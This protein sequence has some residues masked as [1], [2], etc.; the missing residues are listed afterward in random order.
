MKDSRSSRWQVREPTTAVPANP[1]P[2][3]EFR[4]LKPRQ[5][6]DG[7]LVL[8][9][10]AAPPVVPLTPAAVEPAP[11]LSPQL[12]PPAPEPRGGFYNPWQ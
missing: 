11:V 8:V 9:P 3:S 12:A 4:V 7:T 6:K 10:L 2:R 5:V 1:P